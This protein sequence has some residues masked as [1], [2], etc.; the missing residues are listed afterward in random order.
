M[1]AVFADQQK[2]DINQGN[3]LFEEIDNNGEKKTVARL[4]DWGSTI[5]NTKGTSIADD[6]QIEMFVSESLAGYV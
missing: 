2:R 4:I 3:V 1:T 5:W 6:K